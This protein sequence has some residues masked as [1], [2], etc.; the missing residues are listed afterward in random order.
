[1]RLI[2]YLALIKVIYIVGTMLCLATMDFVRTIRE[3]IWRGKK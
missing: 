3:A 1:M 2:Q